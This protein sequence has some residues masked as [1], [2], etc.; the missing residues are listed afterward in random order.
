MSGD[1]DPGGGLSLRSR[2]AL[3]VLTGALAAALVALLRGGADE[4]ATVAVTV[5][6][7]F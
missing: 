6:D 3:A 7:D 2:L 4:R 5:P 1:G